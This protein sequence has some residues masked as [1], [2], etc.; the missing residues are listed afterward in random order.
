MAEHIE[1]VLTVFGFV[2]VLF[3]TILG[4]MARKYIIEIEDI[5]RRVEVVEK[6]ISID[7]GEIKTN[8]L[9]RFADIKETMARHHEELILG[10]TNIANRVREQRKICDITQEQKK[11]KTKRQ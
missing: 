2:M 8:Y 1:L 4:W 10:I 11:P 7:L 9:D 3:I 6:R 5:E